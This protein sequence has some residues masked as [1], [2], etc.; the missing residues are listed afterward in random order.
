MTS[1]TNAA[2]VTPTPLFQPVR[3]R[4]LNVL[5]S[6][7]GRYRSEAEK[8]ASVRAYYAACITLGAALEA[9][10]LSMCSMRG[11]EV[12]K[13]VA[14]LATAN[15]P[16]RKAEQWQFH[17]LLSAA[18]ALKWLPA[19][20]NRHSRPKLAEW[21]HLVKELRNLV[22]P[23]RHIREYSNLKLDKHNWND[24]KAIFDLALSSILDLVKT[25]LRAEMRRRGVIP[26]D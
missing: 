10:L 14:A 2:L 1:P 11:E 24:A 6:L 20:A 16:P 18:T 22:H 7:I 13:Y 17:H 26:L 9:L 12:E 19:R 4:R 25:D 15:R 23:G 5:L 3:G 21:V 8:S